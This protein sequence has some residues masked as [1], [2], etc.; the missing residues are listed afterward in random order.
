MHI[1]SQQIIPLENSILVSLT[2]FTKG[3]SRFLVIRYNR[4]LSKLICP[5]TFS[6]RASWLCDVSWL[7]IFER[8]S[9]IAYN[10]LEDSSSS[11]WLLPWACSPCIHAKFFS[12]LIWCWLA[13]DTQITEKHSKYRMKR[14]ELNSNWNWATQ[15]QTKMN[16]CQ[17]RK[18]LGAVMTTPSR[19]KLELE[20]IY[21]LYICN[22]SDLP[23]P[24]GTCFP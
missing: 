24:V 16:N 13:Q 21:A 5:K 23:D 3:E 9:S 19:C 17:C 12:S 22:R 4:L 1:Q 14:L 18:D 7:Y 2:T 8:M 6:K 20:L 10:H 15:N 11:G